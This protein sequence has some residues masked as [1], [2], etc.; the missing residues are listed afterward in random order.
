VA[1]TGRGQ[2][3][4]TPH[5]PAPHGGF[6]PAPEHSWRVVASSWRGLDSRVAVFSGE[7]QD[8]CNAPP[9]E[10]AQCGQFP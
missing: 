10:C 5:A 2:G 4:A 9:V 7:T 6:D 1:S 8:V 3:V